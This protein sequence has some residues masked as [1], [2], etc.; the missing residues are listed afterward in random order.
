MTIWNKAR[1]FWNEKDLKPACRDLMMRAADTPEILRTFQVYSW[2][3]IYNAIG[4]YAWHK[5]DA[6]SEYRPPPPYGSLAGFLKTGVEKY[7]DDSSIDQQFK[8]PG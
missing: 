7:H 8:E 3:E 4:N 1:E 5:F 6:G 2:D